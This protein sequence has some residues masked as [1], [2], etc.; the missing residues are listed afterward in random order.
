MRRLEVRQ[1]YR[2]SLYIASGIDQPRAWS[3]ER[4]MA[5]G[6]RAGVLTRPPPP[7]G[8]RSNTSYVARVER[9]GVVLLCTGDHSNRLG[10]FDPTSHHVSLANMLCGP[11][12]W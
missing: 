1:V 4:R 10:L 9:I 7:P 6:Q 3:E 12:Q 11:V 2:Q 8:A 5:D